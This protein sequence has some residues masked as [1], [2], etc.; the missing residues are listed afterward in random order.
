[1]LSLYL[2]LF[3]YFLN[4]YLCSWLKSK[5][6]FANY[7]HIEISNCLIEF[8][9]LEIFLNRNSIFLA[10]LR[11]ENI[12]YLLD[13]FDILLIEFFVMLDYFMINFCIRLWD[14]GWNNL[15][16]IIDC[17]WFITLNMFLIRHFLEIS[18]QKCSNTSESPVHLIALNILSWW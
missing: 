13:F 17:W 7:A 15:K 18:S 12:F 5:F 11:G 8:Y 9:L 14:W 10:P 4:F 16:R 1:M 6:L 2:H 3:W